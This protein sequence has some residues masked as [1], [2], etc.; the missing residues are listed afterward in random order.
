AEAPPLPRRDRALRERRAEVLALARDGRVAEAA[1]RLMDLSPRP[2]DGAKLESRLG[3]EPGAIARWFA[4]GKM[5]GVVAVDK[6]DAWTTERAL[7]DLAASAV[8]L[9]ESYLSR[10]P[11]ERGVSM[12]TVR[13]ALSEGSGREAAE[14]A[15]RRA[16]ADG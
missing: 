5:A 2:L 13:A 16:A 11:H 8:A 1:A 12:E 10:A 6:G 7:D 3:I 9:V 4:D 14:V 15:L